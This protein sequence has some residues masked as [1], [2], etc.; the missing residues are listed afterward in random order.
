MIKINAIALSLDN[1][2]IFKRNSTEIQMFEIIIRSPRPLSCPTGPHPHPHPTPHTR[3]TG[4]NGRHVANDIF[5]CIFVN[6][7]FCILIEISLS[8]VPKG[9][10]DNN[11]ALV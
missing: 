3:T 9:P 11:P 6:E 4:Q 10:I 8:F 1:K 7:K 5:K 2:I